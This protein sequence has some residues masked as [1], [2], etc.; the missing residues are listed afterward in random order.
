MREGKIFLANR[1][2]I[3]WNARLSSPAEKSKCAGMAEFI[4][5]IAR[6]PIS[7]FLAP[8]LQ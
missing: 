8:W 7:N 5:L 1:V 2:R 4:G 3:A 6:L